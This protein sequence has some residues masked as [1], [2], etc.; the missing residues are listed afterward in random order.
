MIGGGLD[1]SDVL[2]QH[3]TA[4]LE[5]FWTTVVQESGG[6]LQAYGPSI[7]GDGS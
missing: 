3:T 4:A 6:T 1:P 2:D 5:E 7:L